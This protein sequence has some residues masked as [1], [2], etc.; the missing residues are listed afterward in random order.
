MD[1]TGIFN[2]LCRPAGWLFLTGCWLGLDLALLSG[3]TAAPPGEPSYLPLACDHLRIQQ[4]RNSDP[5]V[6]DDLCIGD[7]ILQWDGHVLADND[8]MLRHWLAKPAGEE[9]LITVE[10]ATGEGD[11]AT[12]RQLE[13]R[14]THQGASDFYQAMQ[15]DRTEFPQAA[16]IYPEWEDQV[17][18]MRSAVIQGLGD[19]G[20]GPVDDLA[21]AFSR[22]TD[23]VTGQYRNDQCVYLMNRPFHA[24]MWARQR[25]DPLATTA[26][27]FELVR[28]A[29]RLAEPRGTPWP[30]I[31]A[32]PE[33]AA[34][35]LEELVRQLESRLEQIEQS[36]E[37]AMAGLT[38]QER[39]QLAAWCRD[40]RPIWRGEADWERF[41]EGMQLT[42]RVDAAELARSVALSARLLNDVVPG[43]PLFVRLQELVAEAPAG[44]LGKRT[45]IL[46]AEDN[47]VS[48]A[49]DIIID[50]GGNDIYLV[51]HDPD[52]N[53]FAG[54]L[55]I[56]L[57]GDD[58][59][60]NRGGGVAAA[61]GGPGLLVDAAGNDQYLGGDN[62]LGFALLGL[63]VLWD[64][65]GHDRY[66]GGQFTQ[67]AAALGV[68]LVVDLSG[69]DRYD[70][71]AYAQGIGLPAGCGA[72]VDRAGDDV[73]CGTGVNPSGYGDAGE[74]E[75]WCQ[76]CGWG[77]RGAAC[78]GIG[79]LVD[80]EGKDFYRA[81]QFGLGCGYF[82][83]VGLVNDRGGDDTFE[84]SRY[85]LGTAAHYAV[86]MVLD[87]AGRDEYLAIR[88]SAVAEL[89][90]SW[91]LGVAV[92][93]DAAGD[94]VYLAESY[95][96]GGAAQNA[97][98][99]F[100]DKAGRDIYR[101]AGGSP[102][103]AAGYTGGASYGA[104][105]LAGN[106][107][108]F[109]DE[110]GEEDVYQVPGRDNDTSGVHGEHAIWIDR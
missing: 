92:L 61:V 72:I 98:G 67:G 26:D 10:R 52:R 89:G 84:C 82:F 23:S 80:N 57:A 7:R 39:D 13:I 20:P 18:E 40:F 83:G 97:Y 64:A 86:G 88:R 43:G 81:G 96:L 99:L 79:L 71:N 104:G 107:A 35:D 34:A 50:P 31:P 75:G 37:R 9:S 85:G 70:A 3:Q 53:P 73:Y 62:S 76:G 94:D 101:S 19:A 66:Q 91:D 100:W 65:A 87:D 12:T 42:W 5:A 106:V 46:D 74:F 49:S 69:N 90:S 11:Q 25:V 29:W 45:R 109:L 105:R 32:D 108:L 22:F 110:G 6:E 93:I 16:A 78:G 4:W 47:R 54:R 95:A 2:S 77:F 8:E 102:G 1:K 51:G 63:G 55:L 14:Y 103:E 36:M 33:P 56:D 58:V 21:A 60:I 41:V 30:A 27:P 48:V 44:R 38:D 28:H 24:E 17:P 68:G 59:W 15:G